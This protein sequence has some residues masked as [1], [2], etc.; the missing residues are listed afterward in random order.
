[1]GFED[2]NWDRG[3]DETLSR[4]AG[5]T[6]T[7]MERWENIVRNSDVCGELKAPGVYIVSARW[8]TDLLAEG[9]YDS[10][11]GARSGGVLTS[12]DY[13]RDRF[14]PRP[15]RPKFKGAR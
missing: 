14:A 5:T 4:W 2:S 1:M 11:G 12:Q 15:L 9:V 3:A 6:K 8:G 10:E 7:K 13:P